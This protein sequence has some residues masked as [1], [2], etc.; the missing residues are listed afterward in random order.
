MGFYWGFIEHNDH[1]RILFIGAPPKLKKNKT[2]PFCECFVFQNVLWGRFVSQNAL[3]T[4]FLMLRNATIH[5]CSRARPK[6]ILEKSEEVFFILLRPPPPPPRRLDFRLDDGRTDGQ[7]RN[8]VSISMIDKFFE[9]E[10]LG[11]LFR[12]CQNHFFCSICVFGVFLT[13]IIIRI[14][15]QKQFFFF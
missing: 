4:F 7:R 12:R 2:K 8:R 14:L 15:F 1:S 9:R 10:L 13:T 11:G 3:R 6:I 5:A